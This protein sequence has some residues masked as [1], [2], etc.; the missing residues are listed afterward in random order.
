ML[1]ESPHL[2]DE[3]TLI[4]DVG[5]N[6][7]LILGNR[8]RL[9]AASSPT[10]PAYVG[11]EIACGHRAAPRALARQRPHTQPPAATHTVPACALS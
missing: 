1:S 4:V 6:A 9:L 8:D 7:E 5:T 3:I 2:S 11:A 10:A